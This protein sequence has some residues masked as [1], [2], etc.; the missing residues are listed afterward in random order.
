MAVCVGQPGTEQDQAVIADW[1][2][3]RGH[4]ALPLISAW[5]MALIQIFDARLR[6]PRVWAY[7]PESASTGCKRP[8]GSCSDNDFVPV[9]I[10]MDWLLKC[11][12]VAA[13]ERIVGRATDLKN[14]TP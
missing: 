12:R 5:R 9:L 10:M 7:T 1:M 8:T 2:L 4:A 6:Y 13:G 3:E 14:T 11:R